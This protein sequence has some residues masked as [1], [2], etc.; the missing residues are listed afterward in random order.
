MHTNA[1]MDGSTAHGPRYG[2][3]SDAHVGE[4]SLWV[5]WSPD[6]ALIGEP[7][8]ATRGG[9][10]AIGR[11]AESP[12]RI[13][14]RWVSKQH[15]R[16]GVESSSAGP[17]WTV[18]DEGATHPVRVNGEPIAAGHRLAPGDVVRFGAT[19]AVFG[20]AV[21]LST[22]TLGIVGQ[23]D[24]IERVRR[25]IRLYATATVP[26]PVVAG[27]AERG[28]Q[29]MPVHVCGPSGV[30]KELVAKALHD[31]S[32]RSGALI[33]RSLSDTPDE[34]IA[35]TLFGHAR[36]AFTGADTE[37]M[38]VFAA[39]AQGTLFLDEIGELS[40]MAQSSLL[41]V[42]DKSEF[43]PVGAQHPVQANVRI[44]TATLRDLTG[45]VDAGRF[46][47]DL[48]FRL[49]RATIHV[50]PLSQRGPD[51][52]LLARAFFDRLLAASGLPPLS[53]HVRAH[54]Q[55]PFWMADLMQAAARASWPGNVRQLESWVAHVVH[56]ALTR[57]PSDG[58]ALPKPQ[59]FITATWMGEPQ[60]S[61]PAAAAPSAAEQAELEAVFADPDRLAAAIADQAN[62]QI[63]TFAVWAAPQLGRSVESTRRRI[64]KVLGSERREALRS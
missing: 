37:R 22:D 23:S 42:I 15:A 4:L 43:I 64:Y 59:G 14:D 13:P 46:R 21:P 47:N 5:V 61:A 60:S 40:T 58:Q 32:G 45:E 20:H 54:A 63:R 7:L 34:L 38:G 53:D 1:S 12:L 44:V 2:A 56:T 11:T 31:C 29:P 62:G 41:R 24:A 9:S 52:V 16:I 28:P 27:G 33:A 19:V 30:G 39:A 49:S 35:S 3:A 55:G 10:N 51:A 25:A 6:T 50:P 8:R 36:G 26:A 17:V 57:W 18:F 48:F